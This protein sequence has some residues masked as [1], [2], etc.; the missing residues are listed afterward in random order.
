MLSCQSLM[1]AGA[2]TPRYENEAWSLEVFGRGW[3][4]PS[5]LDSSFRWNDESRGRNDE[6]IPR[7]TNEMLPERSIPDRSQGH[8]FIAIAHPCWRRH[9][10]L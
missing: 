10:K 7:M 2:G 1:P 3:C 5:P 4:H 8:A 9:T 6:G